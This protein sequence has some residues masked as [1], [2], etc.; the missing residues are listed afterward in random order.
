M[1]YRLR[2]RAGAPAIVALAASA[3][4][5]LG[6]LAPRPVAANPAAVTVSIVTGGCSAHSAAAT[7]GYCLQPS[8]VTT[9]SGGTVTWQNRTGTAQTLVR[10]TI[11]ACGNDGGGSG[12]DSPFPPPGVLV[13]PDGSYPFTFS[14]YG[15]YDYYCLPSPQTCGLGSVTVT[16]AASPTPTPVQLSLGPVTAPSSTP[17]PAPTPSP[18]PSP[19]ASDTPAAVAVTTPSADTPSAAASLPLASDGTGNAGSGPPLVIIVLIILTLVAIGGGVLSFRL[20]R[21]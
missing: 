21:Q 3:A 18:T 10:C 9:T 15:T 7:G 1:R 16:A 13:T 4:L 11:P 5:S 12:R 17:T 8:A 2:L 20:F 19:T 14:G 6:L